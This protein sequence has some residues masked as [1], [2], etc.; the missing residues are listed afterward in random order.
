MQ[1]QA[2]RIHLDGHKEM[3]SYSNFAT[4]VCI[5]F[6]LNDNILS[7]HNLPTKFILIFSRISYLKSGPRGI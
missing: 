5:C 7:F 6:D 2:Y 1:Y 3:Q 4:G